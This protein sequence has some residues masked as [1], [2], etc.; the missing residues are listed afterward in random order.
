MRLENAAADARTEQHAAARGVLTA[1]LAAL[2]EDSADDAS[3]VH[4]DD[5]ADTGALEIADHYAETRYGRCRV[6]V[7]RCTAC[8]APAVANLRIEIP[9][10][11]AA[12]E[13]QR[14]REASSHGTAG[15]TI[16]KR[17]SKFA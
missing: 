4:R 14:K 16:P 12:V 11:P 9:A 2:H 13:Q 1:Y 10:D 3:V 17:A 7:A 6:R 5:C 8:G 15:R